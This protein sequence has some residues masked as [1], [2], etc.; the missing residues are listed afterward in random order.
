[1]VPGAWRETEAP[2]FLRSAALVAETEGASSLF[3]GL[4]PRLVLVSTGGA[5]YFWGEE[6]ASM[7]MSKAGV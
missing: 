5:F 1:S 4:L 7:L 6:F 2:G 3:L